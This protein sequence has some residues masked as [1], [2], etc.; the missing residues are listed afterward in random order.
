VTIGGYDG[1][2]AITGGSGAT[3]PMDEK[4]PLPGKAYLVIPDLELVQ[5]IPTTKRAQNFIASLWSLSITRR[6]PFEQADL[7]FNFGS[8]VIERA[9]L[10]GRPNRFLAL[11]GRHQEM[12][13]I[14][15]NSSKTPMEE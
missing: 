3:F 7:K 14:E 6:Q 1:A 8:D 5:L 12:I 2:V 9:E 15:L 4:G 11:I 10:P 13:E